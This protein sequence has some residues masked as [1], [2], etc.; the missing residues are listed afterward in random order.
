MFGGRTKINLKDLLDDGW[1]HP[2]RA[3]SKKISGGC[4]QRETFAYHLMQKLTFLLGYIWNGVPWLLK[5]SV[6]RYPKKN[7]FSSKYR[8]CLAASNKT[9]IFSGIVKNLSLFPSVKSS[10]FCYFSSFEVPKPTHDGH[11]FLAT[12]KIFRSKVLKGLNLIIEK[13][14]MPFHWMF[15]AIDLEDRNLFVFF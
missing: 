5:G 12:G 13:C 1:G 14:R 8:E 9:L 11:C 4:F 6:A 7:S 10:I 15:A 2:V 3:K